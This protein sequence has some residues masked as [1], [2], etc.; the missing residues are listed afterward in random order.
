[1]PKDIVDVLEGLVESAAV[2]LGRC[3]PVRGFDAECLLT[4]S[5]STGGP[6]PLAGLR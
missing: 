4:L 1:M 2:V 5:R 6:T 3:P